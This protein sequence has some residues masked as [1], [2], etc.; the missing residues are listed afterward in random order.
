MGRKPKPIVLD[1]W[2]V[3]SYLEGEPAA[4]KV[5]DLIADAHEEQMPLL[6][7][8]VNAG[9]VWYIIARETSE[10]D[11]NA[12]IRQLHRLGVEFIDADLE[13]AKA[14]GFFKSRNRMSFADCFA[15]AL[16]R[17]RKAQLATGEPEFKQI[18][19]EISIEWL[20]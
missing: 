16:A 14:A 10:T 12:S 2:A 7:S 17:Q 5:A 13:L 8:V 3:I 4:Q 6:M 18:E 1:S 9:E 19:N 11:D 15:A 20:K